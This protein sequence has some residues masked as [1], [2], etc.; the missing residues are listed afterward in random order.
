MEKKLEKERYPV[1]ATWI[2][3][4]KKGGNATKF[5]PKNRLF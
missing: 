5:A 3:I 2:I 1:L 4:S